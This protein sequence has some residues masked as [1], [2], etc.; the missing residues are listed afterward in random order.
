MAPPRKPVQTKKDESNRLASTKNYN[1]QKD[2][3]QK[4]KLIAGLIKGRRRPTPR[5]L[6]KYDLKA[7]ENG[8][9][10]IPPEYLP[11]AKITI[12]IPEPKDITVKAIPNV[13]EHP[14]QIKEGPVTS[15]DIKNFFLND[16][17][18]TKLKSWKQYA[19]ACGNLFKRIGLVKTMDEDVMPYINNPDV[20]IQHINDLAVSDNTRAKELQWIFMIGKWVPQVKDQTD[21]YI[22]TDIYGKELGEA[23]KKMTGTRYE[24]LSEKSVY[25]WPDV[26]NMVGKAF[27]KSSEEYLFFKFFEEVPIRNEIANIYVDDESKPNYID[28]SKSTVYI[29]EHKTD[30]VRQFQNAKYVVSKPLMTMV[31]KSLKSEPRTKL[32]DLDTGIKLWL[33][34]V[35]D[36][37]GLPKFPYGDK[38]SKADMED[39]ISGLRHTYASFANSEHNKGQYPKEQK[40]ADLMLH[41]LA[42]SH[43]SYRNSSFLP[44]WTQRHVKNMIGLS[45]RNTREHTIGRTVRRC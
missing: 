2:E 43:L 25:K 17:D 44:K 34:T 11:K 13:V 16:L 10:I 30:R 8:Q 5:T 7:D 28:L 4:K 1:A 19:S 9:L 39:T 36:G 24:N 12:V 14:K 33:R 21:P 45:M 31:K 27:G 41:K 37:A 15:E 26:V 29:N 23:N 20:V 22:W 42:Q 35:L 40:L 18:K 3:I 38:S 32:F 6:A